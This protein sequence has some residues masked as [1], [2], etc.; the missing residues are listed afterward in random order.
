MV[1]NRNFVGNRDGKGGEREREG[2]AGGIETDRREPR[3]TPRNIELNLMDVSV[4]PSPLLMPMVGM[5]HKHD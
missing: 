3:E 5:F 1:L 4:P 2:E